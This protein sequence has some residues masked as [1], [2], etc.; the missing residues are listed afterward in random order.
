MILPSS[1]GKKKLDLQYF[2]EAELGFQEGLLITIQ[3]ENALI[4]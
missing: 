1:L 2:I 3:M 4:F